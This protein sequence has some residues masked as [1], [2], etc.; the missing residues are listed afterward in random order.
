MSEPRFRFEPLGRQHDRSGFSC[1]VSELDQN[2][3]RQAGQEQRRNVSRVFLAIDKERNQIAG[4]YSLSSS[5]VVTEMLPEEVSR[6]LPRYPHTPAILLGRL[7]VDQ[8]FQGHGVGRLLLMDALRRCL[9]VSD[10]VSAF[11]ILVDA[12][13]DA[14][15]SFYQHYG[16]IQFEDEPNRLFLP[17]AT[18]RKL[19]GG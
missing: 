11:A 17:L 19:F 18:V 7:A 16:F 13:N 4:Y 6:R 10:E 5:A 9:I 15:I 8:R 3:H 2:L 12:K 1:G 14:A